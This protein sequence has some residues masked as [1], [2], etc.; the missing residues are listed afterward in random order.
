MNISTN[1]NQTSSFNFNL[2]IK[3]VNTNVNNKNLTINNKNVKTENNS[4]N[5]DNKSI[6]KLTK[7][8]E[9]SQLSNL[10]KQKQALE[11]RMAK[12]R[13]TNQ[14]EGKSEDSIKDEMKKMQEQM[15]EIDKQIIDAQY[16]KA[17]EKQRETK[18][19]LKKEMSPEEHMISLTANLAIIKTQSALKASMKGDAKVL[20]R[21]IITDEAHGYVEYKKDIL[22]NNVEY[23]KEALSKLDSKVN[24]L[25]NSILGDLQNINKEISDNKENTKTE[26]SDEEKSKPETNKPNTYTEILISKYKKN[27]NETSKKYLDEAV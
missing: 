14:K 20:E 1:Y 19:D 3:N 26:E 9:N 13:E 7:Q 24:N 25:N 8:D 22:S 4:I 21:E 5:E 11:E 6:I 12:L 16:Q 2:N 23:K 18:D 17:Q 15:E 10:M 27:N